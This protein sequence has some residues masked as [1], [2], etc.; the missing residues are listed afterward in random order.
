MLLTA[1]IEAVV[2][3]VGA[4]RQAELE[5]VMAHTGVKVKTNAG[6]VNI[7]DESAEDSDKSETALET[8]AG[9]EE[10]CVEMPVDEPEMVNSMARGHSLVLLR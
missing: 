6:R 3:A 9:K 10:I 2:D 8:A 4:T 7:P 5:L 1:L